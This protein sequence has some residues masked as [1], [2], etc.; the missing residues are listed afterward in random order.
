MKFYNEIKD[1]SCNALYIKFTWNPTLAICMLKYSHHTAETC[2]HPGLINQ[3]VVSAALSIKARKVTC[4]SVVM[5]H[6]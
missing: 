1:R 5:L 3:D 2:I 6:H 4:L